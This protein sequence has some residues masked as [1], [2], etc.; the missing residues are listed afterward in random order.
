M[1]RAL[2]K[3]G[4]HANSGPGIPGAE[5]NLLAIGLA[6]IGKTQRMNAD[7]WNRDPIK[8]RVYWMQA[9]PGVAN[10]LSYQGKPLRNWWS[11][12]SNWDEARR[13]KWKLID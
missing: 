7:R 4:Y 6:H 3:I 9:I 1:K 8:W 2:I 5:V 12:V 11:F 10:G 13:E